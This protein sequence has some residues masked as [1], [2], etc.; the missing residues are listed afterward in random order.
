M[1]QLYNRV[2]ELL[3]GA[4]KKV[5]F[6]KINEVY[7]IVVN[8]GSFPNFVPLRVKTEKDWANLKGI[9]I[10]VN[11]FSVSVAELEM[12]CSVIEKRKPIFRILDHRKY[13]PNQS[14]KQFIH[15]QHPKLKLPQ[16]L[17]KAKIIFKELKKD[18]FV[19]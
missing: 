2:K 7:L 6:S 18:I 9:S 16:V 3:S 19:R 11:F 14:F 1:I 13:F 15:T 4:S 5:D 17:N 12:L 8:Q 10:K